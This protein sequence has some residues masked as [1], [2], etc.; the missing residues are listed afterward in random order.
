MLPT[1]QADI[2]LSV[3]ES[4]NSGKMDDTFIIFQMMQQ[5]IND[6]FIHNSEHLKQNNY[7]IA[8]LKHLKQNYKTTQ[9]CF[10][11]HTDETRIKSRIYVDLFI[12]VYINHSS[13]QN[14][15]NVAFSILILNLEYSYSSYRF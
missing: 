14:Y 10:L 9:A 12:S 1:L 2:P 3:V 4:K 8:L 5:T 15:D 7:K 13:L 11:L 6:K